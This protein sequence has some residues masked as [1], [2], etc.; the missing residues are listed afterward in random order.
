M[1]DAAFA[2]HLAVGGCRA[3][4]LGGTAFETGDLG[5]LLGIGAS[6]SI[7]ENARLLVLVRVP[8]YRR[9]RFGRRHVERR[10]S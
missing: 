9:G 10:V 3:L 5:A 2:R 6:R 7:Y 1:F 8:R 4:D